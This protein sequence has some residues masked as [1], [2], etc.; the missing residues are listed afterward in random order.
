LDTG[1]FSRTQ[2]KGP[3]FHPLFYTFFTLTLSGENVDSVQKCVGVVGVVESRV[4][5]WQA[6]GRFESVKDLNCMASKR[7]KC[8]MY[9]VYHGTGSKEWMK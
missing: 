9:H 2:A 3:S 6:I 4:I 7:G 1:S 8:I 5:A